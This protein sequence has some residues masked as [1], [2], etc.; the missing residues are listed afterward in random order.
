MDCRLKVEK[1][2]QIEY[3][4]TITMKAD[5]WEKLR[6]QLDASNLSSSY[7]AYTMRARITDLLAQARKIYW[8]REA[9]ASST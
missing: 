4:L 7:P 6:D 3:T 1:P 2:G 8:P 9:E 5:D